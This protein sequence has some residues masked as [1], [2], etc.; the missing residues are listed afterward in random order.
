[1]GEAV[2]TPG[3][4]GQR[5]RLGVARRTCTSRLAP[6]GANRVPLLFAE[7]SDTVWIVV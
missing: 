4:G 1:M 2:A 3:V 7:A 6:V 5:C